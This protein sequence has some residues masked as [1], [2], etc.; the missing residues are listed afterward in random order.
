M[1]TLAFAAAAFALIAAP[2]F[3]ADTTPNATGN[4]SPASATALNPAQHTFK[5]GQ[6]VP[7]SFVTNKFAVSEPEKLGLDKPG[8][9]RRWIVVENNAYLIDTRSDTVQSF[10]PV[11]AAA[12]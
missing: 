2:A 10:S 8:L 9:D 1:K 4:S 6:R 12:Q 7:A 3:A 5:L 11:K